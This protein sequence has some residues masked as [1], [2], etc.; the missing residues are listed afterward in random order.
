[1]IE[2]Y[3]LEREK[4]CVSY[5][6]NCIKEAAL[7]CAIPVA[8]RERLIMLC[9]Q[10]RHR[11]TLL[12]P[13]ALHQFNFL[14]QSRPPADFLFICIEPY[15]TTAWLVTSNQLTSV[16]TMHHTTREQTATE[17]TQTALTF[18]R[19]FGLDSATAIYVTA[20]PGALDKNATIISW[21]KPIEYLSAMDIEH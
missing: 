11:L 14:R 20:M 15:V 12:Q 9:L 6:Q 8:L 19:Q 10:H 2:T 1:M 5:D 4:W 13:Y 16:R 17:I 21:P 3:S 7:I 18:A